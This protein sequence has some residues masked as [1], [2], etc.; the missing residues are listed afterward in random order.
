MSKHFSNKVQS[1]LERRSRPSIRILME[2][3]GDKEEEGG[4]FDMPNETDEE[5]ETETEDTSPDKKKDSK[6]TGDE[7]IPDENTEEDKSDRESQL[8]DLADQAKM[9]SKSIESMNDK[10][11]AL[12]SETGVRE[13]Q[14]HILKF[15]ESTSRKSNLLAPLSIKN[16]LSESTKEDLKFIEK[17]IETY[18]NTLD[19]SDAITSDYG[20]GKEI[21]V[22]PYV[23]GAVNALEHFDNLFS[24]E[25]FIIQA[26]AN[27]LI[28]ITGAKAKEH[29]EEFKDEFAKALSKKDIVYDDR[30]I[31]NFNYK[32]AAGAKSTG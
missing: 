31:K 12:E 29:I 13:I 27:L 17:N 11:K 8:K 16:Y 26:V 28:L 3:E 15:L 7:A 22:L 18:Q 1:I 30:V 6:E 4:L 23:D 32:N 9:S 24:K 19:K 5:T 2:E 25:G 10:I 21:S 14:D 20:Q